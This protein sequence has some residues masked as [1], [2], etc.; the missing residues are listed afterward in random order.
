MPISDK[1]NETS[2]L[3]FWFFPSANEDASDEITIWLNG[4]SAFQGKPPNDVRMLNVFRVPDVHL[5]KASSKR[6][7]QSAGNMA[8]AALCITLG[9]GQ[10]SPTWCG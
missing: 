7:A 9:T 2:E 8:H 10:L 1:A 5:W 3:Y 6:T 4:V